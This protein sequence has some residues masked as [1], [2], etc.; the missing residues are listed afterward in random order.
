MSKEDWHRISWGFGVA[1]LVLG[2]WGIFY[3]RPYLLVLVLLALSP[4]IGLALVRASKGAIRPFRSKDNAWNLD[5]FFLFPPIALALRCL[6]D[7][8][9]VD[10]RRLLVHGAAVGIAFGLSYLW[11][12]P[13][14]RRRVRPVEWIFGWI[15]V[16]SYGWAVAAALNGLLP[17]PEP[18]RY[19]VSIVDKHAR[20]GKGSSYYF[21]LPPFGPINNSDDWNVGRRVFQQIEVGDK[22]CLY[23]SPGALGEPWYYAAKCAPDGG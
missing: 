10:G 2:A 15:G 12:R 19:E 5:S 16:I 20:G 1:G 23:I 6:S 22:V 9:L 8:P 21:T 3:P 17:Q 11:I 18:K 14:S 4:V 13:S 7:F